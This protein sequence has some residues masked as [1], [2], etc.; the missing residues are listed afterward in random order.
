[1]PENGTQNRTTVVSKRESWR[2]VALL[3]LIVA[4]AGSCVTPPAVSPQ[5]ADERPIERGEQERAAPGTEARPGPEPPPTPSDEAADPSAPADPSPPLDGSPD[6]LGWQ[7]SYVTRSDGSGLP[8]VQPPERAP[9]AV[10]ERAVDAMI[11]SLSIEERIGQLFMPGILFDARGAPLREVDAGTRTLLEDLRPGGVILFGQNFD[12]VPQV[13]QLVTDLQAAS[14]IPLIIS[15]DQEGGLVSRLNS[16]ERLGASP[17]P[18]ARVVGRAGDANLAYELAR[19][20][21]RELRS[22]GISMNFAPV[23]DVNTNPRNPVVGSRSFGTT[24]SLVSSMVVAGVRGLQDEGVSAVIKHFPGHGDTDQ[25]THTTQVVVPHSLDRLREIEL[26]PFQAGIAAGTDGVMTAHLAVPA[27]TGSLVPA[28][29]SE[30]I[31]VD[32]LRDALGFDGVIVTDALTMAAVTGPYRE[33]ELPLL[34]LQAG[35]DILLNARLSVAGRD[36][37]LAAVASGA[38]SEARIDESV[39]RVLRLK[40]ERGLLLVPEP[41]ASVPEERVVASFAA[42]GVPALVRPERFVSDE[43]TVGTEE[44]RAII[45]R[46]RA[47]SAER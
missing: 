7:D 4:T 13:R 32:L 15:V 24:P 42:S 34:A 2:R 41:G 19:V 6:A 27:I 28:T 16:S 10:I 1:M 3:A 5:P 47:A 21:A 30:A 40:V 9:A 17:F 31:L 26:V 11:A 45:E 35:A 33:E 14:R 36:R 44:H 20:T 39:R 43:I 38:V 46:V 12:T 23:A 8:P 25:D 22:L 37:I 18:S 29:L